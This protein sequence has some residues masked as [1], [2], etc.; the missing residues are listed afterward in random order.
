MIKQRWSK[1]LDGLL[2]TE[3]NIAVPPKEDFGYHS[4]MTEEEM[5]K[6]FGKRVQRLQEVVLV[7]D[8]VQI[9]EA[10]V[11]KPPADVESPAKTYKLKLKTRLP[12]EFS[13][14]KA[15]ALSVDVV[16]SM[17]LP[18]Q[19]FKGMKFYLLDCQ[20]EHLG[21]TIAF[22]LEYLIKLHGGKTVWGSSNVDEDTF[23]ITGY[24]N[25]VNQQYFESST[26]NIYLPSLLYQHIAD[27]RRISQESLMDHVYFF[28]NRIFLL[29]M[30]VFNQAERVVIFSY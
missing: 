4:K 7:D 9:V 27:N 17:K 10:V 25:V 22:G 19:I 26:V 12:F 2:N 8:D 15:G 20:D 3:Y 24:N 16:K 13:S 23:V 21:R 30:Q 28:G 6:I 18:R 5:F 11:Q 1:V 29:L 14:R